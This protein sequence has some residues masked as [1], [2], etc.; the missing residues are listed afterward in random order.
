MSDGTALPRNHL[1]ARAAARAVGPSPLP[2]NTHRVR[3]EVDTVASVANEQPRDPRAV[4]GHGIAIQ[5]V[6][7]PTNRRAMKRF[8]KASNACPNR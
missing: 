5:T 3:T 7:E 4:T 1:R 2:P 8:V 6:N